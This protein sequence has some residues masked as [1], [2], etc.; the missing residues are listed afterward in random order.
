MATMPLDSLAKPGWLD[1][2]TQSLMDRAIS[3]E[4]ALSAMLMTYILTGL[5]FMLLP[6]TFLGVWNLL[7]I[8]KLQ[9]VH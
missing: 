8:G 6:G 7:S 5:L 1:D 9:G 3:R 2:R 4:K